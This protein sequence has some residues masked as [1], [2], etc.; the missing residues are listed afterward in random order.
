M[1]ICSIELGTEDQTKVELQPNQPTGVFITGSGMKTR[2]GKLL[3]LSK[4]AP[5]HITALQEGDNTVL[6][7]YFLR[8]PF[9]VGSCIIT[10]CVAIL[11]IDPEHQARVTLSDNQ[12]IQEFAVDTS[13]M[14]SVNIP[15]LL[16]P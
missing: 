12:V 7:N 15:G 4:L 3:T 16:R 5:E 10:N 9:E 11:E 2:V 8:T 6:D 14:L 1:R 13:G